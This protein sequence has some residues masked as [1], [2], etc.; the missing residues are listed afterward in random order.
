MLDYR[1]FVGSMAV[2]RAMQAGVDLAEV[3]AK[4]VEMAVAANTVIGERVALVAEVA[5]DPLAA[6]YTEFARMFPEKIAAMQQ[7][8]VALLDEWRALQRD[9]G[10]YMTYVARAMM[11][12]W[13][14]SPRDAA[15]L[16]ER[17]S[18]QGTRIAVAAIDAASVALVPFHECAT[19][20]ARRLS[21]RER[22]G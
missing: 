3:S 10:D 22:R 19:S 11:N 2:A 8:G 9:V 5:R 1:M 15:E 13:P 6:D 4:T 14:P 21:H 20:N 16:V 7:A 12:G 17:T 18:F